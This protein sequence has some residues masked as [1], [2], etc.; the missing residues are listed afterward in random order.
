[1]FENWAFSLNLGHSIFKISLMAPT[2][3]APL[4]D[5]NQVYTRGLAFTTYFY[6]SYVARIKSLYRT[7]KNPCR[8]DKILYR[9]D[10][11]PM[12]RG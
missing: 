10:K 11:K 8:A 2:M 7:D 9:M 5:G 1:M 4:G 12:L 3:G 6:F